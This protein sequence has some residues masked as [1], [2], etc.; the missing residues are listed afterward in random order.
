MLSVENI[1]VY[2]GRQHIIKSVSFK[3]KAGAIV[4]LIGPNGA[5]KTT[6]MKTIL[7]LTNFT[8]EV[9][10]ENHPVTET[11]HNS[12][13]HV[14]AL[15]EHP[16][17]YP[18]MTG[19]Q[20]LALYA[21]DPIQLESLIVELEMSSYINQK[22]KGYS[23]GM[24]QKLGI[25]LALLNQPQLVIL[26][27]PVNG[28]DIDATILVRQVIQK[29]AAQG[30]AFLIASHILNELEKIVTDVVVIADGK[31]R[32]KQSI[33]AFNN[34][35]ISPDYRLQTT[36]MIQTRTLLTEHHILF[37]NDGDYLKIKE[38]TLYPIQKLCYQ[39]KIYLTILIPEQVSFER[40]ILQLLHE[41]QGGQNEN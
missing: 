21:H 6:I 7:G 28:L 15:I 1:N 32:I 8:G 5:G 34:Q 36:A 19:R 9:Q 3:V 35:G 37:E 4:G 10:I 38:P 2:V 24:K 23:L 39:N 31:V 11:Q 13:S 12:L 41:K 27:E 18:F 17:I 33:A 16:A 20:N 29:Y 14:G 22:A 40:R 30:T 26:D 25:A